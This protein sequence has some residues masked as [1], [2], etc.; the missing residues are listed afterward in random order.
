VAWAVYLLPRGQ[1]DRWLWRGLCWG[2]LMWS[3]PDGCVYIGALSLAE[4]IFLSASRRT[5]FVSLIKSAA[6]CAAIYGPWI[7]WA[8]LYYGSPVPHTIIAKANV[9]Q[10]MFTQLLATFDNLITSLISM[11][12]QTFRPIYYGDMPGWWLDG[13]WG[14][15]ISGL[16]K[17]VGIVALL[18]VFCPV[19][20]RF[21][22]A[23]SFC[24]GVMCFYLAYMPIAYPWYFPPAMIFGGVAFARAGTALALAAGE[25][26]TAYLRLRRPRVFVQGTFAVLAVGSVL[27]FLAGCVEQRVQQVEI[28]MGNRAVLGTWLKENGKPTDTVY[29]EPLGYI[30]YYCGMRMNDFPGLVAPEVVQIRRRLPSDEESAR[31]ARYL[32][33]DELKPDWVVLRSLEYENLARLPLFDTFK[34]N[35]TLAHEFNVADRLR[36]YSFL[37]GRK[38]LQFDAD[39]GVFRRNSTPAQAAGK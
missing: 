35:Y 19:Q 3:R 37:P 26:L 18:Y 22:R 34:K 24:F 30:G 25:Q 9:E 29:L 28:E 27:M 8:W 12:A 6:V 14:R 36:Q 33:I 2:G 7:V 32:V 11:A 1:A 5:T 17:A 10:G 31:A 13:F 20:D 38:S 16:T 4:L 23:M 21:G 15:A 39:Y